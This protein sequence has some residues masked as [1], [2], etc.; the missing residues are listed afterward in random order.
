MNRQA[1]ILLADGRATTE[2]VASLRH[3]SALCVFG[4]AYYFAYRY[5]MSFSQAIASPFWFPDS[6]L[7]CALLLVPPARWWVLFLAALPIRLLAPVSAGIPLWFL[8]ATFANDSI[9]GIIAAAALRHFLRNPFRF[10]TVRDFGM[11][12]LFAVLLVPAVSAF[13]GAA[14][15]HFL[16]YDFWPAL[17]QWFLGN[18]LTHLIVTPVIFYWVL[19]TSLNTLARFSTRWVEGALL[20]TGLI[21]TAYIAFDSEAGGISFAEPRF[22]AP[23]PF[24]FWAAIR[25][26]MLGASGA[27]AVTAF[28]FPLP[29]RLQ[30]G[31]VFTRFSTPALMAYSSP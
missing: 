20:T 26:G 12:C 16:G 27:I 14:A 18:A 5:G 21:V 30:R 8:L 17:E 24:L 4:V 7:L 23:V 10:E 1:T 9:K 3:F 28:F 13:G 6:V 31:D 19:G 2:A 25:F 22:Y 15:L 29:P 11:Y